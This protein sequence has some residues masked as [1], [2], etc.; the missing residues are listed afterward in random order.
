ML[1]KKCIKNISILREPTVPLRLSPMTPYLKGIN[2]QSQQKDV[3]EPYFKGRG[4]RGNR[5]FPYSG[6][7]F[8]ASGTS[9]GGLDPAP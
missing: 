9:F 4:R 5:R 1:L 2:K 7:L 6:R 8:N 3:S